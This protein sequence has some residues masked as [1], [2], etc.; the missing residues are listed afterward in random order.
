MPIK[1]D[2][3][4]RWQFAAMIAVPTLFFIA[5]AGGWGA[6]IVHIAHAREIS[7]MVVLRVVGMF[8]FP[9]GVILGYIY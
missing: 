5:A 2:A 8:V 4:E 7:G 3:K 9:I 6:N 1:L